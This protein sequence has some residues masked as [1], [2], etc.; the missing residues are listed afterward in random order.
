SVLPARISIVTYNIWLTQRWA[1]RAPA[2]RGI[3]ESFNPDILC[4]Q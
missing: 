1:V 4:L 3:L 2:L